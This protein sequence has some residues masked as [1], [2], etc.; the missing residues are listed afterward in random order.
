MTSVSTPLSWSSWGPALESASVISPLGG[1][2]Q[3]LDRA[4]T[5]FDVGNQLPDESRT[6]LSA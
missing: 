1:I 5:Y 6:L 4:K 2:F 3:P